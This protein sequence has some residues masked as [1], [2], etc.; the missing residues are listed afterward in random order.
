[1]WLRAGFLSLLSATFLGC[2]NVPSA[3]RAHRETAP[4]LTTPSESSSP[5]ASPIIQVAASASEE[6]LPEGEHSLSFYVQAALSR[7]PEIQAAERH[8]AAQDEVVPQVT[9]L[10]DPM[11]AD[12]P[13]PSAN[14]A[15]QTAAGRVTNSFVLAQQFPWFGKLR[16]RGEVAKLETK[17]A[18][19]QLAETQLKVI[20]EVK[21][22]YFDI[23]YDD[24]ALRIIDESE[25]ILQKEFVEPAKA[26]VGKSAKLDMVRSQVELTKLQDQRIDLR[27]KL[28]QAQAN[29]AKALSV[30]PQAD[31]KPAEMPEVPVVSE[32]MG[33]LYQVALLSRPELQG[34][35]DAVSEGER[36]VELARLNYV[37]DVSLG[38]VWND[39]T[40][41]GALSKTANGENSLGIAVGMNLPIWEPRLRAAVRE[42]QNRKEEQLRL[43]QAARDETFRAIRQLTVQ[44]LAQ[45]EQ[46]ELLRTDLVPKARQALSL[47]VEGYKASTV[48]P[49]RVVDNWLQL[50]NILLEQARLETSIGKTM[51]SLERMVGVQLTPLAGFPESFGC[52]PR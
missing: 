31:L 13:W 28:K 46:M 50:N 18:L 14:Q 44:A 29:L 25:R 11:V 42:A 20:E 40:T 16:L 45:K 22:A 35:I 6:P 48:D 27:Q 26:G 49:V 43:Y 32:Q 51:A 23:Y 7:N 1:M 38:L 21:L 19:T 9:S 41:D 10:P 30:T 8:V 3:D 37:P 2:A 15:P 36:F 12:V 47:A 33:Q 4:A 5:A 52:R 39:L 17:I 24:Q 34:R